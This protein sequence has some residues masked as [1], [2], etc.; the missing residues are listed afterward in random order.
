MSRPVRA[1]GCPEL[2]D[3]LGAGSADV[4]EAG[5]RPGRAGRTSCRWAAGPLGR[6]R[7]AGPEEAAGPRALGRWAA[8]P[9][10]R[11]A[12]G[13]L[14]RWAAGPLG[15][16]AA[17]PLG[18]WAAGP[19][20]RWAAGPLG[21][22]AAGPLGRWAAGP[23]GRWAAGPLGRCIIHRPCVAVYL[24]PLTFHPFLPERSALRRRPHAVLRSLRRASLPAR[25][26]PPNAPPGGGFGKRRRAQTRVRRLRAHLR[27]DRIRSLR[28]GATR[29]ASFQY[30]FMNISCDK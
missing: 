20:G 11:W 13:P 7:G 18:R 28:D 4:G 25:M 3:E 19:L 10:G 5:E 23:L 12:A 6:C 30:V 2:L 14:G 27:F 22:W 26:V 9:L 29:R 16:W 17:G 8:G 1:S 15:R 24:K 21:R